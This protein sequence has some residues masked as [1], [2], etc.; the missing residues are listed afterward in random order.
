M[1]SPPPQS[2]AH[3]PAPESLKEVEELIEHFLCGP[4]FKALQKRREKRRKTQLRNTR[5]RRCEDK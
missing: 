4:D 1:E 3:E 5:L 2:E